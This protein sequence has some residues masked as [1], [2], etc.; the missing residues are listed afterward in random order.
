MATAAPPEAAAAS[1]VAGSP[2]K[3]AATVSGLW[4]SVKTD[5]T[6]KDDLDNSWVTPK[7]RPKPN[8]MQTTSSVEVSRESGLAKSVG[9]FGK[10][11]RFPKKMIGPGCHSPD[12]QAFYK[13]CE[14]YTWPSR[15]AGSMRSTEFGYGERFGDTTSPA[16]A[17]SRNFKADDDK[18]V[19][20]KTK[21][22]SPLDGATYCTM[23][24]K[25]KLPSTLVPLKAC[26][27]GPHAR[28][29][30]RKDFMHKWPG[31]DATKP[32]LSHGGRTKVVE[33]DDGPGCAYSVQEHKSVAR[34]ASCPDSQAPGSKACGKFGTFGKPTAKRFGPDKL[35]CSPNEKRYYDHSKILGAE[36]YCAGART[37]SFGSGTKTDFAKLG[38]RHGVSAVTYAPNTSTSKKTSA[39]DGFASRSYSP[40]QAAAHS[41]SL[42]KAL[43][44]SNNSRLTRSCDSG[45]GL[46]R[47]FDGS[48]LAASAPNLGATGD[49][50]VGAA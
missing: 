8:M 47:T 35:T 48:S 19:M 33:D 2:S 14:I 50:E 42:R 3:G 49:I 21:P 27:P 34:T 4:S 12:R 16:L 26:S 23:T 44:A 6:S 20:S 31:A 30:V 18:I 39:F 32:L 41:Q 15:K 13:A 43:G 36:D 7:R 5:A 45:G 24:M 40:V 11:E 9:S 28:Y 29:E 46:K 25:C 37:C 10:A 22:S 17:L 1:Q 38:P